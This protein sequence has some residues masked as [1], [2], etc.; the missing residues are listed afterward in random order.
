MIK[1]IISVLTILTNLIT[2]NQPIFANSA[3]ENAKSITSNQTNFD[4]SSYQPKQYITNIPNPKSPIEAKLNQT[5][6]KP[7]FIDKLA[8][9]IN[10][11]KKSY[12]TTLGAGGLLGFL[13]GGSLGAIIGIAAIFTFVVVQRSDYIDNFVKPKK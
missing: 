6:E 10:D 2:I 3:L 8:Q 7:T 13:I 9:D 1:K 12:I 11:N 5:E 4:G